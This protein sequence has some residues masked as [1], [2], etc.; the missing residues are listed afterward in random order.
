MGVVACVG[1]IYWVK[2]GAQGL[3][4]LPIELIRGKKSLKETKNELNHDLASIREKYR[5]I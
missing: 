4:S 2:D 3:G 5:S 1:T